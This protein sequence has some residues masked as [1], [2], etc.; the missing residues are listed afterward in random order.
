MT[1]LYFALLLAA[2]N[3]PIQVG[4]ECLGNPKEVRYVIVEF[5]D[6]NLPATKVPVRLFKD[7]GTFMRDFMAEPYKITA[8]GGNISP[9]VV[10][11]SSSAARGCKIGNFKKKDGQCVAHY[12]FPCAGR[13]YTLTINTEPPTP[14]YIVQRAVAAP[15]LLG[16][17]CIEKLLRG[18]IPQELADDEQVVIKIGDVDG[19]VPL[20]LPA[21]DLAI[22]PAEG[23]LMTYNTNEIAD[24]IKKNM[25]GQGYGPPSPASEDIARKQTKHVPKSVNVKVGT[26]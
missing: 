4:T 10:R 9:R 14:N 12:F 7:D 5:E 11:M 26:P 20:A 16:P 13:K 23:S 17:V 25:W 19:S 1:Y 8:S 15:G 18:A 21:I 22:A 2:T 24:L 3:T 6:C